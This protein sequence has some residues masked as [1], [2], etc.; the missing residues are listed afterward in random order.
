MYHFP[1]VQ[2][3]GKNKCQHQKCKQYKQGIKTLVIIL[4]SLTLRLLLAYF[5]DG[6]FDTFAWKTIAGALRN[7]EGIY[8]SKTIYFSP[9]WQLYNYL[10]DHNRYFQKETERKMKNTT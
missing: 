4:A 5:L 7:G 10:S 8:S 6:S 3:R 2:R 9:T 1:R